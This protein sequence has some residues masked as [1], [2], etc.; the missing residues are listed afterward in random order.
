[1]R[2]PLLSELK[3]NIKGSDSSD[4]CDGLI[5]PFPIHDE[6]NLMVDGK[7][8]NAHGSLELWTRIF[9]ISNRFL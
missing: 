2:T 6:A 7:G 5:P 1:M 4:D 8:I 3:V 9:A